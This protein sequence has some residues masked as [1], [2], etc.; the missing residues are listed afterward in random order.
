MGNDYSLIYQVG[1]I[2]PLFCFLPLYKTDYDIMLDYYAFA[3]ILD[4]IV[5]FFLEKKQFLPWNLNAQGI[6]SHFQL[7][8]EI[9]NCSQKEY[10]KTIFLFPEIFEG[11]CV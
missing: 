5:D 2:I 7:W 3:K 1:D 10:L 4:H 6:E 8:Q 9:N 11:M